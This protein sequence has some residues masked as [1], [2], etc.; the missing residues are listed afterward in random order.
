MNERQHLNAVRENA[1]LRK[2]PGLE[3]HELSSEEL[4]RFCGETV[5]ERVASGDLFSENAC[6]CHGFDAVA[7]E[8]L[9]KLGGGYTESFRVGTIYLD[10]T[11]GGGVRAVAVLLEDLDAGAQHFQ[12]VDHL[13]LPLGQSA[14]FAWD[15]ASSAGLGQHLVDRIRFGLP[16]S[17][18]LR[19]GNPVWRVPRFRLYAYLLRAGRA[20][21]AGRGIDVAG[22]VVG[23]PPGGR[24]MGC[25]GFG[26]LPGGGR[27]P[28]G[29]R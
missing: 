28:G 5:V 24:W 13:G 9:K 8:L 14:T 3:I 23:R 26:R 22:R 18:H 16:V 12:P 2:S 25:S 20:P 1:H 17:I 29:G 4:A 6:I 19:P 21:G 27:C 15:S 11:P 10:D 7:R